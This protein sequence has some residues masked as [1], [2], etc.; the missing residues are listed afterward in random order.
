MRILPEIHGVVIMCIL[1]LCVVMLTKFTGE[2][3][4]AY[5]PATGLIPTQ[6]FSPK[7]S[8]HPMGIWG[9]KN[10]KGE[11]ECDECEEDYSSNNPNWDYPDLVVDSGSIYSL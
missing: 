5:V 10:D 3:K 7:A 9:K 2:A 6:Q 4:D 11:Q 8:P 1:W